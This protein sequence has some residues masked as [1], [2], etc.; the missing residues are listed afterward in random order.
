M[1]MGASVIKKI[2]L[3]DRPFNG[4]DAHGFGPNETVHGLYGPDPSNGMVLHTASGG[5]ERGE[6]PNCSRIGRERSQ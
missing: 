1:R 4:S 3:S 6:G 2:E 5:L